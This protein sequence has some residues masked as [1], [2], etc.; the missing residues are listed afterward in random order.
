VTP[1]GQAR[2]IGVGRI[3]FGTSLFLAPSVVGR[4]WIAEDADR[5]RTKM[6]LRALGIRDAAIGIGV[7]I[8][9][10][11]DAPVRGWLEAGVMADAGDAAAALVA[12]RH[13]SGFTRSASI[14]SA[15]GSAILGRRL[16]V[17]LG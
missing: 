8:A 6:M 7:L 16:A 17:Q 10:N 13:L 2:V 15:T 11:R 9:L 12:F 4:L 5:P 3:I 14:V 1:R